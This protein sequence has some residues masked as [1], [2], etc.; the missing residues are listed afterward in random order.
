M[1]FGCRQF[2]VNFL[3]YPPEEQFTSFKINNKVD[4][5]VIKEFRKRDI[6][7]SPTCTDEV[8]IRRV[9]LDTGGIL[10][11]PQDVRN[12]LAD[13]SPEK[14]KK[15]VDKLLSSMDFADYQALKWSDILRIKAEFPSNLWPQA[16]QV[17]HRWLRESIFRN[18][19]YNKFV[20]E[21]L[22]S[23]GSN[24]Q[25]P[26]VNFY[27][28]FQER[29]PDEIAEN[30]ALVFMGI[31]LDRAPWTEKQLSGMAAFFTKIGYKNTFEW[32][33]E[34]V[35]FNPE[36]KADPKLNLPLKP[37][38]LNGKP[39]DIPQDKDPRIV[40][41]DWLIA[42]ANPWFAKCAVNRVWYWLLDRGIVNPS[43][44]MRPDNPPWSP[45]LLAF[46]EKE[47]VS[48]NYDLKHIYRLILNSN[49]YQLSSMSNEWNVSDENGFS[50]YRI[51]RVDA[52]TLIDIIC[53]ITAVPEKYTSGIPEPYT[54]LP[55]SIRAVKIPDGSISSSFLDMFGRSPRNTSFEAEKTL[56]PSL[57]QALHIFNSGHIQ[58]KLD[59]GPVIKG[60]ISDKKGDDYKIEALYLLILSRYPTAGERKIAE[61]YIKAPNTKPYD[62]MNDLAWALLN[63]KEFILKH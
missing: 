42:P 14:R 41:A 57:L 27:R 2:C 62:A 46:L 17:Y 10:P 36:A 25:V 29:K 18:K 56:S 34:I 60:I 19:P 53:Q 16:A 52:E 30:I 38:P 1:L 13:K 23:N 6:P 49:T 15:L 24:F 48:H 3:G 12:F 28:A 51:R 61:D 43:D 21:L 58:R 20:Y 54:F 5:I 40:F 37:V 47:L 39:L 45:E 50:R 22:T 55:S 7:P 35:Y 59:Q 63:T 31:R 11:S 9:Y 44:D 32:K 4:E 8:F 26:P 33:E